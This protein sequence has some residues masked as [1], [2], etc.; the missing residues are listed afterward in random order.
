MN[1]DI[2]FALIAAAAAGAAVWAGMRQA[3]RI[4]RLQR[5]AEQDRASRRLENQVIH[6]ELELHRLQIELLRA[7]INKKAVKDLQAKVSAANIHASATSDH[8]GQ[9]T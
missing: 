2:V 8:K 7:R 9:P 3:E 6:D 1:P 4:A 5:H